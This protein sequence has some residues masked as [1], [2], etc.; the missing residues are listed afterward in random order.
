MPAKVS[1][2]AAWSVQ[3]QEPAAFPSPPTQ[4]SPSSGRGVDE[5]GVCQGRQ[6]YW[7]P[8]R[9]NPGMSSPKGGSGVSF[10]FRPTVAFPR[11]YQPLFK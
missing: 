2:A 8:A 6:P 5:P 3:V 11:G 9:S 10:R 7:V 1:R 4:S